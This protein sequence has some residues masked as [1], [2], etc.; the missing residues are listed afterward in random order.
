MTYWITRL[1][2]DEQASQTASG[3]IANQKSAE[4]AS[5]IGFKELHYPRFDAGMLQNETVAERSQHLEA[6]TAGV[7][8]GDIVI[9]QYPMWTNNVAFEREF[10]DY[11]K[12]KK[13]AKTAAL[14]W[15][16]LSWIYD[17][18]ER[19]YSKDPSLWMLSR[20]DLVIAG[21][22]KIAHRLREEGKVTPPILSMDLADHLYSGALADKKF[23]K[24]LFHVTTGVNANMV[25]NYTA[26]TPFYFIGPSPEVKEHRD[27]IHLLG[28]MQVEKIP[29]FLDGGFGVVH[30]A[31]HSKYKMQSYGAYKNPQK[32]SLFLTAGIPPIVDSHSAHAKWIAEQ[33][34]GIVLDDLNE[35]DQVLEKLTEE[36]Y[37]KML[38]ALRPWQKASQTGY[39]T[40]RA[41]MEAVRILELDFT[42]TLTEQKMD[43]EVE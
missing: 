23:E 16:V 33:G 18:R 28:Q 25:N 26:K 24:K 19:D 17:D 11:I 14:V 41:C 43:K 15:D 37:R 6:L 40:K 8:P 35:I 12:N 1:A 3:I 32:L 5:K 39:F 22:P 20:V 42:D 4:A 36:D 29:S 38:T 2:A 27:N 9:I 31:P 30:Y 7:L 34:V 21:N 13:S 10:M